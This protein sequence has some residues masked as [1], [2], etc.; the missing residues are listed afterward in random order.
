MA[1]WV[2]RAKSFFF[3]SYNCFE[4][5][6]LDCIATVWR[7][8]F[9]ILRE[10]EKRERIGCEEEERNEKGRSHVNQMD[11]EIERNEYNNFMTNE[12]GCHKTIQM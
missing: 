9:E 1:L 5:V 6:C 4:C 3:L 11:Q 10:K 8:L 7:E 2:K 12:T